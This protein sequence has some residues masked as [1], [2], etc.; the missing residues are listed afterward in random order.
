MKAI[1]FTL[2]CLFS[3]TM[4]TRFSHVT[5]DI[6][7]DRELH[8][9]PGQRFIIISPQWSDTIHWDHLSADE[10]I[11][12]LNRFGAS[13]SSGARPIILNDGREFIKEYQA[14]YEGEF[15]VQVQEFQYGR[16]TGYIIPF[17][18]IVSA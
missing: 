8:V 13:E 2:F 17:K 10:G 18:V 14:T 6:D 1:I 5:F 11:R 12:V 7:G 3:I 9:K 4:S 15:E 16:P